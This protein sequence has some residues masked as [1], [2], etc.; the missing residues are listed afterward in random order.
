MKSRIIDQDREELLAISKA[1][2]PRKRLEAYVIQSRLMAR[3]G[4][5][6]SRHRSIKAKHPKTSK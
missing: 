6:G 4:R 5:A 2:T 3:V 1:M